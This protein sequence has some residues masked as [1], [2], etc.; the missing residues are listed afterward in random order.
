MLHFT[1][2]DTLISRLDYAHN[3][4]KLSHDQI[5]KFSGILQC[6]EHILKQRHEFLKLIGKAQYDPTK[7]LYVSLKD[8]I[9]CTDMEFAID[10][11]KTSYAKFETFLRNL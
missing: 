5:L 1:G 6:R 4:M 8:L 7:D 11:A 9:G 10:V 2:Q 3:Q